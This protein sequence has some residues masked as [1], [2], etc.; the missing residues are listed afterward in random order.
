MNTAHIFT[1]GNNTILL[2]WLLLTVLPNWKYTQALVLNGLIVLFA[3]VYSYLVL[4]DI[5]SFNI[6]SFSTLANVKVLF[7][8]DIAVAAGWFH[9]LAFDL[10]VGAYIVKQSREIAIPRWLYTLVLPFTFMFGPIGYLLFFIIK[11][12]KTKTIR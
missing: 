1:Y 9:Y 2:G 7:Q 6:N 11:I 3:I 12:I 8:N 10:F 5:G 4:K